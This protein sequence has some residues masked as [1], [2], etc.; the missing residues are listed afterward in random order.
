MTDLRTYLEAIHPLLPYL[1]FAGLSG[2][3]VWAWRTYAPRS[4]EVVPKSL[5]ALPALLISGLMAG[6]TAS[7]LDSLIAETLVGVLSGL[8]AVGGHEAL[9]RAPGPYVG[10]KWPAAGL[11]RKEADRD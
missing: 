11:A 6:F 7:E 2:L 9:R 4:F 8:L 5:Q 1:L 3:V 10:G